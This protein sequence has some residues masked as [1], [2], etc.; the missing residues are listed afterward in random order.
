MKNLKFL[1]SSLVAHRGMHGKKI[2]ENTLEAFELAIKNNY[3]IEFDIHLLKDK[4]I[5]VYHDNNLK[6]LTG[7]NKKIRKLTLQEINQIKLPNNLKIPT[8]KDTLNFINGKV[9]IIIELKTDNKAG[10]LEKELVKYLDNY[11]GLFAVKSFNPL[12][13]KWFKN[14][15]PNY[16]RG[17]LLSGKNNICH[18]M[19]RTSFIFNLCK[20][21]FLSCNYLL[22]NHK[23]MKRKILKLSWTI[24]SKANFEK[25]KGYFDNLICENILEEIHKI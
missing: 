12:T 5:V 20:P 8:L 7:M 16:I 1:T 14:Y 22:Y 10:K 21:D 2:T 11:K 6:R 23:I 4:N 24:N 25:Y 9:P 13:I 19:M 3:I 18:K 17:L 15:R